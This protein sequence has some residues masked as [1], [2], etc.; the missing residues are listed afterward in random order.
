MAVLATSAFAAAP[1]TPAT[2]QGSPSPAVNHATPSAA[3]PSAPATDTGANKM[4]EEKKARAE[5]RRMKGTDKDACKTKA[6]VHGKTA[7]AAPK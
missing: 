4:H 2:H 5:C 6:E 7:Q 1:Q 3:T